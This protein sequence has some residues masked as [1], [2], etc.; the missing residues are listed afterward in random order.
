MAAVVGLTVLV[1]GANPVE[2]QII[3]QVFSVFILPLVIATVIVLVNRKNL[4]K[5]ELW[6]AVNS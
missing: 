6:D 3:T 4:M 2:A 1:I 5:E